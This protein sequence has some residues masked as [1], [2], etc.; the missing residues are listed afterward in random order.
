MGCFRS[1]GYL[2]RNL[3]YLGLRMGSDLARG[4]YQ[5]W[6]AND[7]PIQFHGVSVKFHDKPND[8]PPQYYH[9]WVAKFILPNGSKWFRLI[10]RQHGAKI[11]LTERFKR[12]TSLSNGWMK[13]DLGL[14]WVTGIWTM[15]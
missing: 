14:L 10:H 12:G 5:C 11:E 13:L 7:K 3:Q 2:V 9:Q 4:M 15:Q 6:K 8:K 1:R